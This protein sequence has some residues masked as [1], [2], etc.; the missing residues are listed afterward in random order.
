MPRWSLYAL[1]VVFSFSLGV[2]AWWA[3]H[4]LGLRAWRGLALWTDA[5]C[6]ACRAPLGPLA[7][8]PLIGTCFGCPRCGAATGAGAIVVETLAGLF[9]V[10]VVLA[11][12][13]AWWWLLWLP[14]AGAAFLAGRLGWCVPVLRSRRTRALPPH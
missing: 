1:L 5:L 9:T 6:D 2:I 12:P 8:L 10:G 7:Q 3:C 4:T 11:L 14:V 13:W